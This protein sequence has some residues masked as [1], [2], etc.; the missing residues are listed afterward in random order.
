MSGDKIQNNSY[1]REEFLAEKKL[2]DFCNSL[3]LGFS[4]G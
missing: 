2:L 4:A 1:L 3:Y